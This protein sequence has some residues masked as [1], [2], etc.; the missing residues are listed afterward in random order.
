MSLS[1]REC[2][3]I[4]SGDSHTDKKHID[5]SLP[6]TTFGHLEQ[7]LRLPETDDV[8]YAPLPYSK[9]IK[10]VRAPSERTWPLLGS[11]IQHHGQYKSLI[12]AAPP[13][14][15]LEQLIY[16][17][18]RMIGL[19]VAG[20]HAHNVPVTVEM[21]RQ[22]APSIIVI[23]EGQT[24]LFDQ[25]AADRLSH[26]GTFAI[27]IGQLGETDGKPVS[28][29]ACPSMR[30][31]ECI[32]GYPVAYTCTTTHHGAWHVSQEYAWYAGPTSAVIVPLS[33]E[34]PWY[35]ALQMPFVLKE[36][37]ICICGKRSFALT[38]TSY[39]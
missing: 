9:E 13:L 20:G 14:W 23:G 15:Q 25:T 12:Y 33:A 16:R 36:Q 3:R 5:E 30:I 37:D 17:S 11:L 31:L 28:L 18:C 24:S 10:M 32:S 34:V 38:Y 2:N 6:I 22:L 35:G 19:P 1:L 8:R 26:N 27:I 21:V 29:R 4:L 7:L 39:A